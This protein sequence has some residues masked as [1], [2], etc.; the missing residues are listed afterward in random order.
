[1]VLTTLRTWSYCYVCVHQIT[2]NSFNA[3]LRTQLAFSQSLK[4]LWNSV[5]IFESHTFHKRNFHRRTEVDYYKHSHVELVLVLATLFRFS[6]KHRFM[7]SQSII[8]ISI[9]LGLSWWAWILVLRWT[10]LFKGWWS[11]VSYWTIRRNSRKTMV[12]KRRWLKMVVFLEIIQVAFVNVLAPG[13]PVGFMSVNIR[14]IWPL[15][16]FW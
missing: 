13:L 10:M 1:M 11:P 6:E 2:S 16:I 14:C 3:S 15:P 8:S 12:L 5:V 4:H 7:H 9:V